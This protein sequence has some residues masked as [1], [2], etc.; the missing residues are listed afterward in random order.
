MYGGLCLYRH[1]RVRWMTFNFVVRHVNILLRCAQVLRALLAYEHF[2]H[3][4]FQEEGA[5]PQPPQS[6]Y[7]L[8][9][10]LSYFSASHSFS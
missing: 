5:V 8:A 6:P 1:M 9:F 10:A 4:S 7:L 2:L 3:M